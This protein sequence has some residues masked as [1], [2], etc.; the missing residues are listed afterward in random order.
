MVTLCRTTHARLSI[1]DNHG[2]DEEAQHQQWVAMRFIP[3]SS[4]VTGV[5]STDIEHACDIIESFI[6]SAKKS[7]SLGII[8]N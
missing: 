2:L 5:F 6:E 1:T 8:Q 3:M 7:L 4:D